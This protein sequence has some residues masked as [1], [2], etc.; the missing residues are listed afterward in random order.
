M[1]F[2]SSITPKTPQIGNFHNNM[3]QKDQKESHLLKK[4]EAIFDDSMKNSTFE[5]E[6]HY[7]SFNNSKRIYQ[8]GSLSIEKSSKVNE[9][10]NKENLLSEI[11]SLNHKFNMI[12]STDQK[13][14]NE[15]ASKSLIIKEEENS[16]RK[17]LGD[18]TNSLCRKKQ[19][20]DKDDGINN[21]FNREIK[22]F[23][24]FD[25]LEFETQRKTLEKHSLQKKMEVSAI[26]REINTKNSDLERKKQE[27]DEISRKLREKK[28]EFQKVSIE[29]DLFNQHNELKQ[30]QNDFNK[31]QENLRFD[32]EKAENEVKSQYLTKFQKDLKE[33]EVLILAKEKENLRILKE[34]EVQL[35]NLDVQKIE[36]SENLKKCYD[37][38]TEFKFRNEKLQEKEKNFNEELE[39]FEEKNRRFEEKFN[40]FSRKEREISNENELLLLKKEEINE[41]LKEIELL[42]KNLKKNSLE[43]DEKEGHLAQKEKELCKVIEEIKVFST[44]LKSEKQQQEK[45]LKNWEETMKKKDEELNIKEKVLIEKS[46]KDEDLELKFLGLKMNEDTFRKKL[47]YEMRNYQQEL[48]KLNEKEK[49]LIQRERKI[50]E[51]EKKNKT[52]KVKNMNNHNNTMNNQ[53]ISV[54][55]KQI[56]KNELHKIF[57]QDRKAHRLRK[58]QSFI[59][60]RKK[61]SQLEE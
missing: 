36:V 29:F 22:E 5:N 34:I 15:K 31:Q 55:S 44:N 52:L 11:K 60:L 2:S 32:K 23:K 39:K 20:K 7:Q 56:L 48:Q 10:P 14:M 61:L 12:L 59:E 46:S 17:R 30:K 6:N 38:D 16:N 18:R 35:K 8:I 26:D 1:P 4:K 28:T 49:D 45:R 25:G 43:I 54:V 40:E 33:K 42:E 37:I 9:N 27:L 53:G 21:E 24:N 58:S 13:N 57:N 19:Q 3:Q 47:E 51:F 41:K 50:V